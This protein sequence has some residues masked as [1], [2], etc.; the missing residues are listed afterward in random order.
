MTAKQARFVEE[1]LIDLNG[2]QA[3]IRAGYSPNAASAIA[4]ENLSKP[5]ISAAVAVAMA[6]RSKRTGITADR[7]LEEIAKLGFVNA[8]DVITEEGAVNGAAMR[9]DT[10]AIQSVRVKIIPT[11]DGDII[12]REIKL[13]DKTRNL[14]LLG[15]HLGLFNDKLAITN[16]PPPIFSGENDLK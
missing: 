2:T 16:M 12:E 10:A 8:A 11:E 9:D 7:V 6:E 14:E 13:Y 5:N 1:Y 3:A 4:S 15:R